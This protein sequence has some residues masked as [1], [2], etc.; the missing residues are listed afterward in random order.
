ME[1]KGYAERG[2]GTERLPKSGSSRMGLR[3]YTASGKKAE[4]TRGILKLKERSRSPESFP[5][6]SSL[7]KYRVSPDFKPGQRYT[8][9]NLE[10]GS[11]RKS[12]IH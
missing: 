4:V 9:R 11:G 10:I 12:N 6:E 2:R 3:I 5:Q 1:L 7:R 8:S